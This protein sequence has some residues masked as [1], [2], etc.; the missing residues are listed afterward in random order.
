MYSLPSSEL[1]GVLVQPIILIHYQ[2]SSLKASQ[3]LSEDLLSSVQ[4]AQPLFEEL[5]TW[6][7]SVTALESPWLVSNNGILS[8]SGKYPSTVFIAHA[9]L[10]TYVWRAL[11]RPIVP[12]ADPPLIIDDQLDGGLINMELP[13]LNAQDLWD[14][15]DL[16]E[17]EPSLE[18]TTD[19]SATHDGIVQNLHQS[20]FTWATSLA[21]LVEDLPPARFHEFWYSCE[22]PAYALDEQLR[23]SDNSPRVQ[24]LLCSNV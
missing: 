24:Y 15:P 14:L 2:C 13:S 11:L 22:S 19:G 18:N 9:T 20:S 7:T 1:P 12:S 8:N 10:V 5:N 6:R 23:S 21:I 17:L 4:T 3:R 16:T